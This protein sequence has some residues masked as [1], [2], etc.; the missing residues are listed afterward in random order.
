MPQTFRGDKS[1][2]AR[3][4][5]K[6]AKIRGSARALACD[7]WRPR[8]PL[9][10]ERYL[11]APIEFGRAT[12]AARARPATRE[13][14]CAPQ[15]LSHGLRFIVANSHLV[16][17]APFRGPSRHHPPPPFIKSEKSEKSGKTGFFH[18]FF[19]VTSAF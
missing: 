12:L 5:T 14:A 18:H 2:Q 17:C 10:D 8:R 19:G 4:A 11:D 9:G 15:L 7:G 3:I 16:H 1:F 6:G 13:G